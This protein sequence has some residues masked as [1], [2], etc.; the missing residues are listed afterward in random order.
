M[1]NAIKIIFCF[2]LISAIQISATAQTAQEMEMLKQRAKEKVKIL[3]D[4]ISFMANPQKE[5][6]TRYRYKDAAQRLFINDCNPYTEIVQYRDGHKETVHRDGVKMETASLRNKIPVSKPMKEYFRALIN[7]TYKTVSIEST[8]IADMRVSR[9][10]PY[11]KDEN[12]KTLYVCSV[13]FEQS[14]IGYRREGRAYKDITHKW[15]V[16]YVTKDEVYDEE[17]GEYETEYIISLGDVHVES[18]QKM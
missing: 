15:C 8:D 5:I 4:N 13:Y 7:M 1:N 6:K 11:G 17:T 12:G 16:C 18:I 2:V 14:F 10:Q 9:L 3:N